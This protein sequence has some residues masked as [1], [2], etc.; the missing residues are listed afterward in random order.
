MLRFALASLQIR[1]SK[2]LSEE[3]NRLKSFQP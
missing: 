3:M 2:L 1:T